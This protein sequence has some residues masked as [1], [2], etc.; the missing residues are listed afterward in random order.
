MKEF[1]ELGSRKLQQD[2]IQIITERYS[3]R[4]YTGEPLREK[5]RL[6]LGEFLSAKARGPLGSPTRL[7]LLAQAQEDQGVLKGLGTYGFIRGATAFMAGSVGSSPNDME[8]YGYVMEEAV[9]YATGLGLG[10]CWLGGTFTKSSFARKVGLRAGESMPAVVA[11]GYKHKEDPIRGQLRRRVGATQRFPAEKL[12]FQESFEKPL[13]LH[14]EEP[15]GK[16]LECVRWAPS[17]SNK[18]PWRIVRIGRDFL[19]YLQR[20]KGYGKGSLLFRLLGLADLQ[21]VDMGI[22]MCHFELAWVQLGLKGKWVKEKAQLLPSQGSL[23]Y[24]IT[25]RPDTG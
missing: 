16:V 13:R 3:C 15:L 22:A 10:T 12:F 19:F 14:P 9:L 5:E 21:R 23:Q 11:L 17:A 24:I 8:D 7:V 20:S 1:Q 18:Q 25:W 6:S 4:R 2:I